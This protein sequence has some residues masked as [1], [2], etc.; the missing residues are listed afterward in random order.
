MWRHE[1]LSLEIA[2]MTTSSDGPP[3]ALAHLREYAAL[4]LDPHA[5]PT[6]RYAV[7]CKFFRVEA[8]YAGGAPSAEEQ[9]LAE[10]IRLNQSRTRPLLSFRYGSREVAI[11]S[12]SAAT[13]PTS[14]LRKYTR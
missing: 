9:A 2:I 10:R 11:G 3:G 5:T 4:A 7:L 1:G 12:G 14:T 13:V 6:K 8:K